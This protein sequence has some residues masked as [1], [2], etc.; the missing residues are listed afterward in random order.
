MAVDITNGGSTPDDNQQQKLFGTLDLPDHN[1]QVSDLSVLDYARFAGLTSNYQSEIPLYHASASHLRVENASEGQN[2]FASPTSD[3]VGSNLLKERLV[4]HTQA[5]KFLREICLAPTSLQFDIQQ[6][7]AP[8]KVTDLKQELPLLRSDNE[9]DLLNFGRR[10]EPDLR[11]IMLPLISVDEKGDESFTWPPHC[12]ELPR[13]ICTQAENEKLEVEAD[14][15][16]LLFQT[17]EGTIQLLELSD[18]ALGCRC[19]TVSGRIR[20]R[21][22]EFANKSSFVT[23][24]RSRLRCFPSLLTSSSLRYRLLQKAKCRR[25]TAQIPL[26]LRPRPSNVVS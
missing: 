17:I 11:S 6:P 16:K 25:R 3:D 14:A 24:T 4:I 20:E 10:G 18:E 23:L 26:L 8:V 21:M 22:H 1:D 12:Q 13:K 19:R 15:M 5:L 7:K 2:C 9:Y